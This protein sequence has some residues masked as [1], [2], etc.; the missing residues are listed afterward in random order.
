MCVCVRQ[1]EACVGKDSEGGCG[2]DEGVI[3]P[4]DCSGTVY[5]II[6]GVFLDFYETSAEGKYDDHIVR[7]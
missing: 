7:S 5:L 3:R 4:V 2:D 1:E 6:F